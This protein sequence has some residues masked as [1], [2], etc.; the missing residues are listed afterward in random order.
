MDAG[1]SEREV[2]TVMVLSSTPNMKASEIAKKIGTTRLDAYNSLE[3]LQRIGIVTSTADR[4]MRFSSPSINE[5]VSHLIEINKEQLSRMEESY[6]N[7]ISGKRLHLLSRRE[8]LMSLNSQ[9]SK[10]ESTS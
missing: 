6:G 8:Y 4:P 5:V 1:L 10:K 7:L 9:Y 2:N 3:R